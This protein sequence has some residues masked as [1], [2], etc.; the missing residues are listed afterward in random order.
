MTQVVGGLSKAEER[1]NDDLVEDLDSME[2]GERKKLNHVIKDFDYALSDNELKAFCSKNKIEYHECDLTDLNSKKLNKKQYFVFSGFK[3][4]ATNAG[5]DHHWLFLHYNY[6][7]DPAGQT[8]YKI[9]SDI[10]Y[11]K[12]HPK[13]LQSIGSVVCGQYCLA[14]AFFLKDYDGDLEESGIE[15]SESFNFTSSKKKNDEIVRLW[16]DE[17]K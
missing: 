8:S 17:K 7:F 1:V 13:A 4:D 16:Y 2:S 3:P 15:F 9:A 14:Y 10:S 5:S 11:V 6:L 12:T